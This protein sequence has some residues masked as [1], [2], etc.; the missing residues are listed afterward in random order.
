MCPVAE[1]QIFSGCE[2]KQGF[3]LMNIKR[4]VRSYRLKGLMDANPRG[5][6]VGNSVSGS[7]DRLNH[8][9]AQDRYNLKKYTI[10]T[11]VHIT[12]DL[13]TRLSLPRLEQ[14]YTFCCCCL[15]A[16][17]M[18]VINLTHSCTDLQVAMHYALL[19]Q[20]LQHAANLPSV[21][22]SCGWHQ[23]H[24]QR[25]NSARVCVSTGGCGNDL[26]NYNTSP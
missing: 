16:Y 13:H 2:H 26:E 21:K 17:T 19:A 24:L 5:T 7:S 12:E 1:R 8:S 23:S 4:C 22:A 15:L 3:K 6:R 9:F 18:I 25:H 10:P 11:T 20:I 14:E